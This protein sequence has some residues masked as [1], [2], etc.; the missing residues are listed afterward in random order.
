MEKPGTNLNLR[1]KKSWLVIKLQEVGLKADGTKLSLARRLTEY[2]EKEA[3]RIW[4]AIS[5]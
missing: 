3:T 5:N 2:Q 1:L 4:K